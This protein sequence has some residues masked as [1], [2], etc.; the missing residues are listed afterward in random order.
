MSV[1]FDPADDHEIWDGVEAVQYVSERTVASSGGDASDTN[2]YA[3][4]TA[5]H[6]AELLPSSGVYAGQDI[7]WLVPAKLL[8]LEPKPGDRIVD[9]E[10]VAWTVLKVD[11]QVQRTIWRLEARNLVLAF[12]LRD[13]AAIYRPDSALDQ[14]K[15]RT[16]A[17]T[18]V[19]SGI[20][21]RFQKIRTE[22]VEERGRR[23]L[24]ETWSVVIDRQL[25]ITNEDQV[26]DASGTIYQVTGYHNPARVDELP[27]IDCARTP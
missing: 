3:M 21:A 23:G 12:D 11:H 5:R 26:R 15:G 14:A 20:P 18:A 7:T 2:I 9:G 19:Y 24:R 8:T 4:R 27:V 25:S 17:F 22:Q 10:D 13:L 6:A 1:T 16:P